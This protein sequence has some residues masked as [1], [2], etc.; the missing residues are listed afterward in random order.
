MWTPLTPSRCASR[1]QSSRVFGSSRLVAEIGGEIDQR[2][3]DEPRHHARIGA[4]AGD[5]GRPA[6]IG[7]PLGE[8]R[9]AQRVVGARRVAARLVEIEARPRLDDGVDVERADL[10]AVAHDVERG[11]V[12]RQVDAEALAAAFGQQLAE[13]LAIVVAGDGEMEEA[14]AAL[15]EQ[16]AVRTVGVDDDEALLVVIE[17][18]LDQRQGALADRAEADHDDRAGDAG[19]AAPMRH[20]GLSPGG[21]R[22]AG[23]PARRSKSKP[24]PGASIGGS[25][26]SVARCGLAAF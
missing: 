1:P 15:V 17:M 5:R 13:H 20:D 23:R 21:G 6:G 8:H 24:E 10:A 4:A 11:G 22:D 7:A 9:L 12:D 18:A 2:L 25:A 26:A 14:D 16:L 3:L 19:V